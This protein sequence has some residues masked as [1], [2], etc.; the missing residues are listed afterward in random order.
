MDP[1]HDPD[2]DRE[3][4][5][6]QGQAQYYLAALCGDGSDEQTKTEMARSLRAVL[7]SGLDLSAEYIPRFLELLHQATVPELSQ[8]LAF[9]IGYH[10][11]FEP[12]IEAIFRGLLQ[13]QSRYLP[14][15]RDLYAGLSSRAR[16]DAAVRQDPRYT[17]LVLRGSRIVAIP[18]PFGGQH[19]A[20]TMLIDWIGEQYFPS[21][22]RWEQAAAASKR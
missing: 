17:E 11:P 15:C 13:H 9:L 4:S 19:Q 22:P 6:Q 2:Q 16:D 7:S 14:E 8:D 5:L 18:P 3:S 20:V 12:P 21:L 1:S 10:W